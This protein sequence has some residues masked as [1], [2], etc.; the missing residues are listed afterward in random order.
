MSSSPPRPDSL[1]RAL[2]AAIRASRQA[3]ALTQQ[4]VAQRAGVGLETYGRLERGLLPPSVSVL[5][6]VC[7][8]LGISLDEVLKLGKGATAP[9]A[10]AASEDASAQ[11]M[12]RLLKVASGLDKRSLEV[13]HQCAR[14]LRK[15]EEST[16]P[17][18]RSRSH[19][20]RARSQGPE[21]RSPVATPSTARWAPEASWELPSAGVAVA[22]VLPLLPG[23]SRRRRSA[24]GRAPTRRRQAGHG[25]ESAWPHAQRP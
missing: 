10:R 18:A 22:A 7:R 11:A 24:S 21:S 25:P 3:A 5:Q 16:A 13:L 6:R 8:V 23:R 2:G 4:V 12:H 14:V 15:R 20:T 1:S 17:A 19:G 9:K